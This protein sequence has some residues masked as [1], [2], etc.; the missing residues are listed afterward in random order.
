MSFQECPIRHL[1]KRPANA[2]NK[3][4]RSSSGSRTRTL[5]CSSTCRLRVRIVAEPG[6]TDAIKETLFPPSVT[7]TQAVVL[8]NLERLTAARSAR[9][10]PSLNACSV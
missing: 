7:K 2:I 8:T 3:A 5:S 9:A 10:W 6:H 4:K 1:G